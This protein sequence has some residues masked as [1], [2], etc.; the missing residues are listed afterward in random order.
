MKI[1][2]AEGTAALSINNTDFITVFK[3][4]DFKTT[5][6]FPGVGLYFQHSQILVGKNIEFT[7]LCGFKQNEVKPEVLD[8]NDR[9]KLRQ[10]FDLNDKFYTRT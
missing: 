4:N 6:F 8:Y 1:S 3:H 10:M 7:N 9:E 5:K 2:V